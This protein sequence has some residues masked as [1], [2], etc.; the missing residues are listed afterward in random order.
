MK[1]KKV[2]ALLFFFSIVLLVV[3]VIL[4]HSLQTEAEALGCFEQQGCQQIDT[5]LSIVH[6]A[7]GVFGFLFGLSF[8]L[9]FFSRGEEA[10]VQRLEEDTQR[11]LS[12][13]RFAILLHA[14]DQN[15]Q[16]VIQI[17]QQEES[18]TQNTL[19]LKVRLSKA[20]LS[21]VLVG[22]EQKHLIVREKQGKTLSIRFQEPW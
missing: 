2:G 4:L 10:I 3:F 22:L 18:I 11:K 17:L 6:F 19:A 8:Y 9:F 14:L 15:E 5:S 16:E 1:N 7:F 13:E 20:K 21:Q 12:A